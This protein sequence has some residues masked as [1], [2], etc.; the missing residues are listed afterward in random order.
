MP[1]LVTD[2]SSLFYNIEGKNNTEEILLLHGGPGVPDYLGS[3]EDS[4]KDNFKTIRF[5]QRGT[6]GSQSI[7]NEYEIAQYLSD[8]DSIIDHLQIKQV[9]IF[10]HSWGGLLGQLWASKNPDRVKSLFLCSPSSGVGKVW[11]T[12]EQEVLRYNSKKASPVQLLK[13]G[14][15][16]LLGMIGFN[17]GYRNIFRLIWTFYF[18]TRDEAPE[19]GK[20]WFFG[21]N[22]KDI[23]KT[24]ESIIKADSRV[25]EK[26]LSAYTAPVII[27]YGK[28]DVYGDSK[29]FVL[30]RFPSSTY[31]MFEYAG[32]LPWLQDRS[33]FVSVLYKFYGIA[34]KQSE[35]SVA[36]LRL[37]NN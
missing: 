8:I 29:N 28:Y 14:L 22:A 31:H 27:T 15:F 9:H 13:L 36:S 7:N 37:T 3:V 10:G 2:T 20:S 19:L 21:I 5:D 35:Q 16:S 12:M 34:D 30:Q 1:Y 26:S 24:R 23:N 18:L 25:F 33:S 11:K 4:L 6:G 32:H 17:Y